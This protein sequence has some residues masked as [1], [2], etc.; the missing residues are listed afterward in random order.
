MI[1]TIGNIACQEFNFPGLYEAKAKLSNIVKNFTGITDDSRYQDDGLYGLWCDGTEKKIEDCRL[2]NP[3]Q[4][5]GN[6]YKVEVTCR[7]KLI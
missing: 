1:N 4:Y 7:G 2:D 5:E 6:L 3:N